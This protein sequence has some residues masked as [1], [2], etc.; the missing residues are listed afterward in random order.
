MCRLSEDRSRSL[1]GTILSKVVPVTFSTIASFSRMFWLSNQ[2][3]S[4]KPEV[5]TQPFAK[6]LKSITY[7]FFKQYL[8]VAYWL[9]LYG[10]GSVQ[11]KHA[12]ESIVF[13]FFNCHNLIWENLFTVFHGH[14]I[15][16]SIPYNLFE[17][18]STEGRET[19]PIS[20]WYIGCCY[21]F[22]W[23]YFAIGHTGTCCCATLEGFTLHP[24][25]QTIV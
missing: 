24:M 16:G 19:H 23:S 5:K 10:A 13:T 20:K 17:G 9:L 22:S 2:A 14:V 18:S 11:L 8:R 15:S 25:N 21:R 4:R 7:N 3:S 6:G 1:V 12:Y